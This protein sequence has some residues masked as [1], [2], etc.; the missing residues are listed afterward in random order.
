MK[1]SGGNVVSE[2][3]GHSRRLAEVCDDCISHTH[4]HLHY[5]NL[6]TKNNTDLINPR[7]KM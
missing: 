6:D 2:L 3:P 1:K 5:V 7:G 4:T